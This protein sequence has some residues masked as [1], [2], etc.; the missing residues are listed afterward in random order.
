MRNPKMED[1]RVMISEDDDPFIDADAPLGTTKT[2]STSDPFSG[3]STL[4]RIAKDSDK[5]QGKGRGKE[6]YSRMHSNSNPLRPPQ[7]LVPLPT[8]S[9]TKSEPEAT[10]FT[11]TAHRHSLTGQ[12][13]PGPAVEDTD[14][15]HSIELPAELFLRKK[16]P[17]CGGP[18]LKKRT[19]DCPCYDCILEQY[20]N[21]PVVQESERAAKAKL[22]AQI[23]R[24][25][26]A[27]AARDAA[28]RG[29][30]RSYANNLRN[31][32]AYGSYRHNAIDLGLG[33]GYA[34]TL[35]SRRV[36][37]VPTILMPGY[38][39]SYNSL[40]TGA[41]TPTLTTRYQ[42]LFQP[43][44]YGQEQQQQLVS[45][46]P[47]LSRPVSPGISNIYTP[48]DAAAAAGGMEYHAEAPYYAPMPQHA[49]NNYV[50][51]FLDAQ[52]LINP[53][54]PQFQFDMPH[55]ASSAPTPLPYHQQQPQ[56][57]QPHAGAMAI[58]GFGQMQYAGQYGGGYAGPQ[59]VHHHHQP[60]GQYAGQLLYAGAPQNHQAYL[61]PPYAQA[62]SFLHPGPMPYHHH[63]PAATPAAAQQERE[64]GGERERINL[65][66]G[67]GGA[68][69]RDQMGYL[70]WNG[71]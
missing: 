3:A 61:P 48:S 21:D 9:P 60:G 34:P 54:P 50:N 16:N 15:P 47:A 65:G 58:E 22:Y 39:P 2:S 5:D 71:V 8:L 70:Y 69:M 41:A 30:N 37:S 23:K 56:Q 36:S 7:L 25:D 33:S 53:P 26:E 44:N 67:G 68:P 11:A 55:M 19:T 63:H 46:E 35:G 51:Q 13:G 17:I 27:N 57:Q 49:V 43:I 52:M 18:I 20:S 45:Y 32:A 31:Q 12:N 6:Q 29:S 59:Q 4:P 62:P 14:S 64:E 66:G 38:F 10:F 40:P 42:P 28:Q 24:K 1:T